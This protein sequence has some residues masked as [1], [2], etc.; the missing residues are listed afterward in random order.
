MSK[1]TFIFIALF[2]FLGCSNIQV[3]GVMCD[4]IKKDPQAT[5]PSECRRYSEDKAQK[6]FDKETEIL[7]TEDAIEFTK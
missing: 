4:E 1:I 3:T 7:S 6:A 5:V 2:S